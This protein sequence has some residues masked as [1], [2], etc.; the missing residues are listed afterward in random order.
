MKIK[1]LR[2]FSAFLFFSKDQSVYSGANDEQVS[3][4]SQT[5]PVFAII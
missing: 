5:A 4:T 1:K 2:V 3:V